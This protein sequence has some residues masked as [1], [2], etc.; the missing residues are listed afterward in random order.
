MILRFEGHSDDTFGEYASTSDDFDNCADGSPIVFKVS[1]PDG[2]GLF[3]WGLY[4]AHRSPVATP[5]CWVI[6]VQ[7]LDE[8]ITIPS[9][10]MKFDITKRGYSPTL[11]IDAPEGTKVEVVR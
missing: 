9:W 8:D 10:P 4:N 11:T 7:Q 3:V 1:S 6:G 2:A 5:G